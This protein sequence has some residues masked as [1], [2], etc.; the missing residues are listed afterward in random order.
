MLHTKFQG[1]RPPGSGKEDFKG[2]Y[3]IKALQ[4][5][6][7]GDQNILHKFWLTYHK[8]SSHEI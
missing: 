1:H 8:E 3:H 6:W 7:S 5:S 4:P 2:F